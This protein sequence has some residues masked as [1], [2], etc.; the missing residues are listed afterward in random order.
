MEPLTLHASC[1][2]FQ[3]KGVLIIGGSGSGKSSLALQLMAYG[4]VFVSDDRT[5]VWH[6]G[7]DIIARAAPNIANMIE[8][9]GIGILN[10]Q[11]APQAKITCIVD[12]DQVEQDRLPKHRSYPLLGCDIPLLHKVENITFA[13]ALLQFIKAGRQDTT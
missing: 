4:A 1:V 3:G 9:R 13:A 10:A 6:V 7:G 8:A 5:V 12:M 11:S 2:A